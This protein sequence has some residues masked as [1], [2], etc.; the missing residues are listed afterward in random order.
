MLDDIRFALRS[1][2]RSPGM[3]AAVI[4][5]ELCHPILGISGKGT[6]SGFR[7]VFLPNRRILVRGVSSKRS[8]RDWLQVCPWEHAEVEL[9]G[10]T[11]RIVE[12][13]PATHEGVSASVVSLHN[14][15]FD[16][17]SR[18][19][20]MLMGAVSAML[21]LAC[22]NVSNLLLAKAVGRAGRRQL[23]SLWAPHEIICCANYSQKGY[24]LELL[25]APARSSSL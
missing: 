2:T 5:S 25:A 4:V 13:N 16:D 17:S 21:L 9:Q 20:W 23:A 6:M 18:A 22:V 14:S 1:L 10:L 8:S 15:L 24:G 19:L 7:P 11:D 3:F 12:Q